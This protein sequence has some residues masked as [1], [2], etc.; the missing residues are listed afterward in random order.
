[1]V[2]LKRNDNASW[3]ARK[4]LPDHVREEYAALYGPRLEAK[5]HAAM[6]T[7]PH[8]VKRQFGEWLAEVE[9]RIG[10]IRARRNGEGIALT[11]Q[12]ARALAGEWYHW[13][14]ARHPTSDLRKWEAL[15]DQVH[16]AL[17]EAVGEAESDW[18]NAYCGRTK[19]PVRILDND[20]GLIPNF[21]AIS[22]GEYEG[23]FGVILYQPIELLEDV[24]RGTKVP[25]TLHVTM[26]PDGT[27]MDGEGGPSGMLQRASPM[28]AGPSQDVA[29]LHCSGDTPSR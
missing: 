17:R 26:L 21:L 18:S 19:Q 7:L 1:M 9:G 11:R 23:C 28:E 12:Q 15:R 24:P 5:F 6:G 13:F 14:I 29:S 27:S 22:V 20:L 16:E 10:A 4:R 8:E 3:S 2:R 25:I